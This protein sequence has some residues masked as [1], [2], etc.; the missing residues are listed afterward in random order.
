MRI[1]SL[2]ASV[3]E[4]PFKLA[5]KHA[6]AER[7]AMQSLWVEARS[8]AG[9]VGC[10]EGCPREYVTGESLAGSIAFVAAHRAQWIER[11]TDRVGL[12]R[13]VAENERLVDAN[14]AAWSAVEIAILDALGREEGV[15]LEMLLDL[16]PL[17]GEFRYTA[18]IGD[19][20]QAAFDAQLGH[21]LKA[22]FRAF[23]IKLAGDPARDAGKVAALRAANIE[24]G[25]VRADANNLFDGAGAAIGHL[26]ALGYP[27]FAL[28]EP[29]RAGDLAGMRELSRARGA[30][31]ILDESAL[32]VAQLEALEEDAARWIVNLRISKMG[33]VIRSLAF[34]RAARAAGIPIVIGAH[35]GESSVLTRVALTVANAFRDSV[36]AQEGAFGTHLLERDVADPPLM[37]GPGG[38]LQSHV[39]PGPG[40]GLAVIRPAA[41]PAAY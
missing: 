20:P 23:K 30:K 1:A 35:V 26:A 17:A 38:R 4:I 36:L 13:W 10:G 9:I 6:S 39:L 21:Y 2:D 41:A 27:F 32:R 15:P 29:L 7:R 34:A 24:P 33:G 25:C 5:F 3:L 28:E 22:G 37:F 19:G 11:I 8:A 31:I 16:P 12:E 40:L 14:P 18:V